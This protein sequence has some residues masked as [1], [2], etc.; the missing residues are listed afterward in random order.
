MTG[1]RYVTIVLAM[2]AAA[3]VAGVLVVL[4]RAG[5]ASW[6][7]D[8]SAV[9]AP[10]PPAPAPTDSTWPLYSP[11]AAPATTTTATARATRPAGSPSASVTSRSVPA[12]GAAPAPF[13]QSFA[14]QPGVRPQKPLPSPT[15]TVAVP[16]NVDGCDHAYGTRLQCVP[17]TFP[18]GTTDKC[19][20]LTEHGFTALAVVGKDR[21]R[22]DLDGNG[23]ACDN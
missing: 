20:W 19:A 15:K 18:E 17:W 21:Q 6:G 12:A 7:S 2:I 4:G 11:A 14:A 9:A 22:L 3:A 23:I 10:V 13:V 1:R 16:V 8:T 5:V